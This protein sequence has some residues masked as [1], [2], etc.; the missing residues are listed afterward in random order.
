MAKHTLSRFL[1]RYLPLSREDMELIDREIQIRQ[2]PKGTELLRT[3]QYARECYFVLRGC[4]RRFYLEDGEEITTEFYTEGQ[5][6]TPASY[7]RR[8]P[9]AYTLQ[10]LEDCEVTLGTPEKT[11]AFLKEHPRFAVV[12]GTISGD[13]LVDEQQALD[14]FKQLSPE[15]RYLRL[16]AERPNL[17]QRVPDYQLASYLG[18]RPQSLS[19]I[20]KRLAERGS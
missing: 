7:I 18:I 1:S 16:L 14:T 20:R 8:E 4:I 17:V 3:G 10:S 12:F 11:A 6:I 2:V 19:R 5:P 13:L 9:S 15:G